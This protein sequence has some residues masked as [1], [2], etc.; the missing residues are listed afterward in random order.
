MMEDDAKCP[1]CRV[2]TPDTMEE[3]IE[4]NM[5]HVEKDDATAIYNLGCYYNNGRGGLPQDRDKALELWL[6]AGE[7]GKAS[8]CYNIGCAYDR[9]EGVEEDVKKAKHYYELAA[10]GG[11]TD[12]WYN[13][14]LVEEEAG[15]MVR[16]L[17]H[18]MIAVGL[19][20][21]VLRFERVLDSG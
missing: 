9:G 13:L 1:F 10:I 17:S 6:R 3:I 7:L 20:T 8:A 15:N 16:S 2:P 11:Y 21:V 5:K 4:M 18:H 14:G 19:H 12:A